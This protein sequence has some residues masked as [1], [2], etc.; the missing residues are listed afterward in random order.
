M[1]NE[2][3]K[4]IGAAAVAATAMTIMMTA[5]VC[6]DEMDTTDNV[7]V[8]TAEV[9]EA[10]PETAEEYEAEPE[11]AEEYEAEPETA[12][13]YEAEPETT[14]E[15]E[16]EPETAEEYEAEPETAEVYEA[17]PE[18]AAVYETEPETAEADE[19]DQETT[20][21]SEEE[22]LKM[23]LAA[24]EQ[25]EEAARA[26]EAETAAALHEAQ[27]CIDDRQARAD[28]A[29]SA[30]TEA[31]QGL[32]EALREACDAAADEVETA[33]HELSEAEAESDVLSERRSA[34]KDDLN[35]A[36]NLVESASEKLELA[37]NTAPGA[38]DM[39]EEK[40]SAVNEAE[41]EVQ[42]AEA[43]LEA[44]KA[45]EAAASEA[46]I[47][48]NADMTDAEDKLSESSAARKAA[49]ARAE[50]ASADLEAAKAAEQDLK[51]KAEKAI[52]AAEADKT[53]ADK[54]LKEAEKAA[55]DAAAAARESDV[56]AADGAFGFYK[57]NGKDEAIRNLTDCRYNS[58]I[59]RNDKTDA[60]DLDNI[61]KVFDHIRKCNE[62]RA[63]HGAAPLLVSDE[64]MACAQAD[65]DYSDTIVAHAEQ[66]YI[67]EN[68]A[69]NYGSD[70]FLQWY[71]KE[72]AIY[73]SGAEGVTGHYENIINPDYTVTGFGISTRGTMQGWITY[74]QTFDTSSMGEV[75]TVDEYE[76]RFLA[77]Y[78]SVMGAKK[79]AEKAEAERGKAAEKANAAAQVAEQTRASYA[80]MIEKAAEDI[81]EKAGLAD[82]RS[83][84]ASDA[85]LKEAQAARELTEKQAAYN[86]AADRAMAS[87]HDRN[88]AQENLTR[89]QE[90]LALAKADLEA[91]EELSS[92]LAAAEQAYNDA[93]KARDEAAKCFRDADA[94]FKEVEQRV[95][96]K[97][98]ACINAADKYDRA[99]GLTTEKLIA[100]DTDDEDFAYLNNLAQEVRT[101]RDTLDAAEAALSE[102]S[103]E[104]RVAYDA[105]SEAQRAHALA[106]AEL[107][108]AQLSYDD[109]LAA[110]KGQDEGNEPDPETAEVTDPGNPVSGV[111]D[112]ETI[113]PGM[114]ETDAE[115]SDK[116]PAM[117]L[118]ISQE[119]HL[120]ERSV[121]VAHKASA[122]GNTPCVV[123]AESGKDAH[124]G[125]ASVIR[126]KEVKTGDNGPMP[127]MAM[128]LGSLTALGAALRKRT[129]E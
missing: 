47:Q 77:Y 44:A 57:E 66:F 67:G 65:A 29:E 126:A 78:D 96:E 112:G 107:T 98:E 4:K 7:Q 21:V 124:S 55:A 11:T 38:A 50:E 60:I 6:A 95:A 86:N 80:S 104:L 82:A 1:M 25:A 31:E 14:E 121:T 40:R 111:E 12:E 105:N 128:L 88:D 36:E 23:D 90:S 72:K 116:E 59:S 62:L 125:T 34:A 15:Y 64:L 70:P 45:S 106:L 84:E 48:A 53:A 120:A 119:D 110:H 28:L 27:D 10:E 9:Y 79:A 19:A 63:R 35:G 3:V 69:W 76:R 18:T 87:G 81:A 92:E 30:V 54:A 71:D 83:R 2:T 89:A 97:S 49:D 93:V 75:W 17:E 91:A 114:S 5:P 109:Y 100:G 103:E 20:E 118:H 33:A 32:S 123:S 108:K 24:A 122:S 101:R 99:T 51:S 43:A 58:Y 46:V 68:C 52:N 16:A 22:T 94:A 85:A 74:A 37:R 39:L 73:D 102:A 61:R 13:V 117:E 41:Q 115:T 26:H 8:E 129:R 127:Y 56:K 113:S 42:E